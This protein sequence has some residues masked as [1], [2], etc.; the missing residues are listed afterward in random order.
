MFGGT[1]ALADDKRM[2]L[3]GYNADLECLTPLIPFSCICLISLLRPKTFMPVGIQI[4]TQNML[5][6]TLFNRTVQNGANFPNRFHLLLLGNEQK[7]V[8]GER[9]G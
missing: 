1:V 8:I 2:V 6:G 7:K 4:K 5:K 9:G 3:C